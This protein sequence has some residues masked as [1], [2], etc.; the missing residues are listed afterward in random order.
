MNIGE[1][2]RRCGVSRST[3][4]YAFS[5]KRAVSEPTR[6]LV[7]TVARELGYRPQ[8]AARTAGEPFARTVGLVIPPAAEQLTEMQLGF[9]GAV[10]AAATRADF[11]VLF[12]PSGTDHDRSFERIA[13]RRQLDGVILMEIRLD[14]PRIER[15]RRAHIPFVTIGRTTRPQPVSSVDLD[16]A[17][18]VGQ[19][20][21]HLADLGHRHIA[22][23]NRSTELVMSGYAPAH[24]ARDGFARATTCR[25]VE[26]VEFCCADND[27]AGESC[28][29]TIL[30][31]Y[32]QVTG[33]VTINEA[34]LPGIQRALTRAGLDVPQG[35]SITGL[36]ARQWAEQFHPPLTAID[37]PAGELAAIAVRLLRE[38]IAKP[39]T[40]PVR[41]LL[42]PPIA[43]RHSTGPA[44]ARR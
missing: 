20:V 7:L 5:G 2:A 9:V 31:L 26:G 8:V 23:I 35:F 19:C 42:T 44:V 29:E 21:D 32:P 28:V 43:L 34:A 24:R 17:A 38:R 11:D 27:L 22:L 1:V 41:E 37:V 4:S 40:E 33:V 13:T 15:L 25:R 18:L 14:D 36:V 6:Q 3:V 12:S 16:T 39:Q 10:I 30:R